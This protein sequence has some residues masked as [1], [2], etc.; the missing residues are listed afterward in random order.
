M[1][2]RNLIYA[3]EILGKAKG[4]WTEQDFNLA[5]KKFR[6]NSPSAPIPRLYDAYKWLKAQLDKSEETSDKQFTYFVELFLG[7]LEERGARESE[8]YSEVLRDSAEYK[9]LKG[10]FHNN[11]EEDK[12]LQ[13]H[14][15][16]IQSTT[17]SVIKKITLKDILTKKNIPL[18]DIDINEWHKLIDEHL[19]DFKTEESFVKNCTLVINNIKKRTNKEAYHTEI[20]IVY[21]FDKLLWY[22]T[23]SLKTK[24]FAMQLLNLMTDRGEIWNRLHKE[25]LEIIK[26]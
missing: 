18:L 8:V 11:E 12:T 19:K 3:P 24:D 1:E 13:I 15:P 5:I 25:Y 2:N 26:K 6:Q 10:L 22:K 16:Q 9:Y 7:I 21:A 20:I 23:I 4:S 14:T 17:A